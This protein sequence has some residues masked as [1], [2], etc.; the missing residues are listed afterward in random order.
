MLLA[1]TVQW[2]RCSPR[3]LL[4]GTTRPLPIRPSSLARFTIRLKQNFARQP[5]A[6]KLPGTVT[7]GEEWLPLRF[8]R[9][10]LIPTFSGY[11]WI[12]ASLL[13]VPVAAAFRYCAVT[14]A[15]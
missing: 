7:S 11:Y 13:F 2:Q 14:T 4:T 5:P 10:Y 8:L 1:T 3:L 15:A 12:R 6:G 9:K